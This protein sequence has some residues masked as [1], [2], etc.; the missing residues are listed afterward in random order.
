MKNLTIRVKLL[1]LS[2]LLLVL[3]VASNLYMQSQIIAGSEA[4]VSTTGTLEAGANALK[5]N[6]Q[7]LQAGSA[8]LQSNNETLQ[9]GNATL[10]KDQVAPNATTRESANSCGPAPSSAARR[11]SARSSPVSVP[12]ARMAS[13]TAARLSAQQYI[14]MITST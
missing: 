7:T 1:I 14:R 9:E 11:R 6:S 13:A 2:G 12:R 5:Q 10:K 3:L 4:L 8:A